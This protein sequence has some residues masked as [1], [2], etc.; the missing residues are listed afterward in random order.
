[1]K[2]YLL[3][4]VAAI[5]VLSS[6]TNSEDPIL[7][8]VTDNQGTNAVKPLVFTATMED[9]PEG[10]RSTY[11]G[12]DRRAEW[13]EGDE[14]NINGKTYVAQSS[15]RTTTF[16]AKTPGDEAEGP[17]YE[18]YFNCRYD[19]TTAELYNDFGYSYKDCFDMPM[20]ARSEGSTVLRFKNLCAVLAVRVP[21]SEAQN[22]DMVQVACATKRLSG[23]FDVV[24]D[25]AVLKRTDCNGYGFTWSVLRRCTKQVPG[26]DPVFYVPVPAGEYR[27]LQI[28]LLKDYF[29]GETKEKG[30]TTAIEKRINLERSNIYEIAF[31]ENATYAEDEGFVRTVQL[32][33]DGPEWADLNCCQTNNITLI[34]ERNL[35]GDKFE[36]YSNAAKS[37][38][39]ENWRNPSYEDFYNLVYNTSRIVEAWGVGIKG[40][41]IYGH[42]EGYTNKRIFIPY[43]EYM[44]NKSEHG[45]SDDGYVLVANQN[46][47]NIEL[48]A[49]TESGRGGFFWRNEFYLRPVRAN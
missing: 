3:M 44:P 34:N 6:C 46:M 48:K 43:G 19:G 15:G 49:V 45:G 2:K 27:C 13:E 40:W 38:W 18:A 20:H 35:Q 42:G 36:F 33:K 11:N 10:T 9:E 30:M 21:K 5:A 39:G 41:W 32:W 4:A 12:T 25:A 31:K 17:I 28:V 7:G 23:A 26:E 8:D 24:D 47:V 14:I 29:I 1:M 37:Q 22:V 16:I